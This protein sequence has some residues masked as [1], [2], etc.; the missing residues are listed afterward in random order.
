MEISIPLF[1]SV[2]PRLSTPFEISAE[3][4]IIFTRRRGR[5][6]RRSIRATFPSCPCVHT[7]L[8]T[9]RR[10]YL[11]TGSDGLENRWRRNRQ[12]SLRGRRLESSFRISSRGP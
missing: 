6:K 10:R 4:K 7:M 2:H 1:G 8:V 3:I 11:V 12:G 5:G 9:S